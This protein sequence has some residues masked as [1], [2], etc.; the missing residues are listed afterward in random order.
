MFAKKVLILT[1]IDNS[2][3]ISGQQVCSMVRLVSNGEQD[4]IVTTFVTNIDITK[5]GQWYVVVSSGDTIH[6]HK[7]DT[8]SN[9]QC[10]MNIADLNNVCCMVVVIDTS[11]HIVSQST[12]GNISTSNMTS[13]NLYSLITNGNIPPSNYEQFVASTVN[14]YE[15]VP[16]TQF[17][18]N[19][20]IK[21]QLVDNYSNAFERYYA[22]GGTDN[23]YDTVKAELTKL[24]VQFPPYYPLINKYKD[25][26][27]VRIDFVRSD[28]YFVMGV[29]QKEGQVKYIC[30]GL[31]A[32]GNNHPD[33]DFCYIKGEKSD[34]YMLFQDAVTGQITTLGK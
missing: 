12:L 24:F 7:L 33:K 18:N 13:S 6:S 25:S 26:Y 1:A 19:A 28:K 20:D 11:C 14:Y 27:F 30:Y 2:Y 22:S 32:N 34:Y 17:V 3:A 8:F 31:P 23:Y 5:G 15:D 21:Y 29:L 16:V 4:V 9:C 10:K